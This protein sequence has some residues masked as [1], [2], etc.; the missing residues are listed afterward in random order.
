MS[1][2]G[3]LSKGWPAELR[4]IAP[5]IASCVKSRE[6]LPLVMLSSWIACDRGGNCETSQFC[7]SRSEQ[8]TSMYSTRRPFKSPSSTAYP[9][10][11]MFGNRSASMDVPTAGT[12]LKLVTMSAIVPAGLDGRTAR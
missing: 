11:S 4:T 5:V 6:T 12:P 8:F 9:R 2:C 1:I 3:T 7:G 10:T